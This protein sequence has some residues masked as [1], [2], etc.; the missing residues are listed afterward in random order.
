MFEQLEAYRPSIVIKQH[1]FSLMAELIVEIL[2]VL[3]FVYNG[4]KMSEYETYWLMG[5]PLISWVCAKK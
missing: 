1:A 3:F 4:L 5:F 2:F